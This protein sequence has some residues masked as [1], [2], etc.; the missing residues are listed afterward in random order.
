MTDAVYVIMESDRRHSRPMKLL[1]CRYPEVC[2]GIW[3]TFLCVAIW[4]HIRATQQPPIYDSLTYYQ[5]AYNFWQAWS[6]GPFFNPLDVEPTTR[7]PGSIL[8]SYPFGFFADPRGFFFRSIFLPPLLFILAVLMVGYD[9]GSGERERRR[10]ALI[11]IFVSTMP[12]LYCFAVTPGNSPSYWGLADNFLAGI[13]AVA[14]AAA[15]RGAAKT[16]MPWFIMAAVSSSFCLLIKPSGALVG[17]LVV[18]A[19][20][21]FSIAGY[22]GMTH[23]AA[24]LHRIRRRYV[25]SVLLVATANLVVLVFSLST[26]YLSHE[27]VVWGQAAIAILK[28]EF[29]T[30]LSELYSVIRLGPG[31][32]IMLWGLL[33]VS[34]IGA[35]CLAAIRHGARP[36][37]VGRWQAAAAMSFLALVVGLWFWLSIGGTVIRYATPFFMMAILWMLPP[38]MRFWSSVSRLLTGTMTILMAGASIN[39]A[40]LLVQIDPSPAWQRRTGV[41]LST[42]SRFDATEQFRAFVRATRAEP[43]IIYSLS[44]EDADWILSSLFFQEELFHPELPNHA[45]RRPLDWNRTTTFRLEEMI[46]SDYLLFQP[47]GDV[48]ARQLLDSAAELKSFQDE[49]ALFTAWAS[50]LTPLD[51]I[52]AVVSSADARIV[53]IRD[54]GALRRSLDNLAARHRWRPVFIEANPQL[55]RQ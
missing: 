26:K 17:A 34:V 19:C 12:I 29:S 9:F 31:D 32:A 24:E 43:M 22:F 41:N 30:P 7:P 1:K 8:M 27:N 37:L 18:T 6:R 35:G 2:I 4:F 11:S 5:K 36:R 20:T 28:T 16:S 53:R 47:Q 45:F 3:L 38:L 44:L 50:E 55:P 39:L 21:V 15:W 48:Q 40:L 52:D 13:A 54:H 23:S 49:R 25:A 14:A 33:S 10:I 42:G 46:S 51:G